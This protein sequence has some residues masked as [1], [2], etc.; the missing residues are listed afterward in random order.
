M[1]ITVLL[2]LDMPACLQFVKKHLYVKR[3]QQ[4]V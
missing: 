2:A 1:E 4:L 3:L